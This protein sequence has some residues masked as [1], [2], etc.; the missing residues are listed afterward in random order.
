[1]NGNPAPLV[2]GYFSKFGGLCTEQGDSELLPYEPSRSAHDSQGTETYALD[3]NLNQIIAA[4]T[5]YV[6][7]IIIP[8]GS[9]TSSHILRI[10]TTQTGEGGSQVVYQRDVVFSDV[11]N[12]SSMVTMTV[13]QVPGRRLQHG[14]CV[15]KEPGLY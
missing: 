6:S 12:P 8:I 9:S 10:T 15:C 4:D 14:Q 3:Q 5:T 13:A 1:M 11:E 7:N 2:T